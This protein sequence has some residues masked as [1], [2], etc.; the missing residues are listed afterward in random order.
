M[1][2]LKRG[3]GLYIGFKKGL[4][5]GIVRGLLKR[6]GGPHRLQ[7][8]GLVVWDSERG[9]GGVCLSTTTAQP[10]Y[11]GRTPL[12]SEKNIRGRK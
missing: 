6:R 12:C 9:G 7:R 1:G 2:F 10:S 3:E 8:R 5:S 11:G 4:T